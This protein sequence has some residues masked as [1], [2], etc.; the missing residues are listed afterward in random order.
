MW[1]ATA[2][3][4]FSLRGSIKYRSIQNEWGH[5]KEAK[6][7]TAPTHFQISGIVPRTRIKAGVGNIGETS[8]REL[9][10]ESIQRKKSHL[11]PS[12]LPPKPL[13][14]K[15][16]KAHCLAPTR[17][18]VS[19]SHVRKHWMKWLDGLITFL[20]QPQVLGCREIFNQLNRK[21]IV[22]QTHSPQEWKW[23]E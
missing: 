12:I 17:H 7:I 11:L 18:L 8:E 9:H 23:K 22:F 14:P 3:L 10:V 21:C 4:Q 6:I 20:Q 15:H 5:N 2:T 13:P 16:M 19:H 1:I